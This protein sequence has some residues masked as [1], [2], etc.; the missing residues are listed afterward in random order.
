MAIELRSR[1]SGC[2]IGNIGSRAK[3][4]VVGSSGL[5]R[6][7]YAPSS[8]GIAEHRFVVTSLGSLRSRQAGNNGP[9]ADLFILSM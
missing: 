1:S 3:L 5:G 9:P 2:L 7:W 6:L 4:F 8:D